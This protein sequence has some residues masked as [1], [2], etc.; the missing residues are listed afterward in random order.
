VDTLTSY[1]S[2]IVVIPLGLFFF[3]DRVI[4]VWNSLPPDIVN[5]STS[6]AFKRSINTVDLSA[7]CIGS[8]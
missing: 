8:V 7:Y 5:F 1:S 3:T 4:N 6:I 2:T